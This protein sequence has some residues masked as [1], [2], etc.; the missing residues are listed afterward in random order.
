[1][2]IAVSRLLPYLTGEHRAQAITLLT[3]TSPVALAVHPA[4][5]ADELDSLSQHE[6]YRVR[7][8]AALHSNTSTKTRKA[9]K[10]DTHA[11]VVDAARGKLDANAAAR[12]L[13]ENSAMTSVQGMYS[14]FQSDLVEYARIVYGPHAV[15]AALMAHSRNWQE[16]IDYALN[17]G[18]FYGKHD[19]V[20]IYCARHE[21]LLRALRDKNA[22]ETADNWATQQIAAAL[23]DSPEA[24]EQF[25]ASNDNDVVAQALSNKHATIEHL[26]QAYENAKSRDD[27]GTGLRSFLAEAGDAAEAL[28]R[29]CDNHDA[30][31]IAR[32]L[33]DTRDE[34]RNRYST[35][36]IAG[37]TP[38]DLPAYPDIPWKVLHS[39]A[40]LYGQI[41][42][43][44]AQVARDVTSLEPQALEVIAVL[45][46]DFVG[47]INEMLAAARL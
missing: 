21:T 30:G 35:N 2:S 37:A 45:D 28:L 1:M 10:K 15:D 25:L 29:R 27:A 5:Q 26:R 24:L 11:A 31:D 39:Q 22:T 12:H 3:R 23:A 36:S 8:A 43:V 9:L 44:I 4:L 20:A 13:G 19:A 38:E 6:N 33:D 32:S 46:K 14:S 47:S 40:D 7:V 16:V 42:E 34:R 17:R 18:S 41:E